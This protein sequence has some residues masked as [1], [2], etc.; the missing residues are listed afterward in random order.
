MA[1]ENKN[2]GKKIG[3]FVV[4]TVVTFLL[5]WWFLKPVA[6]GE[7][8][9]GEGEGE[10]GGGGGGG[11]Y[12]DVPTGF[13]HGGAK[14]LPATYRQP[15]QPTVTRSS[16]VTVSAQQPLTVKGYTPKVQIPQQ[17]ASTTSTGGGSGLQGALTGSGV[18]IGL[19]T[20]H[21]TTNQM[22]AGGTGAGGKNIGML[23][24]ASS[25]NLSSGGSIL[26]K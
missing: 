12:P 6:G 19:T 8:R 16:A 25:L 4:G 26:V 3:V 15:T 23:A 10:S 22:S 14:T 7:E 18:S 11:S 1:E 24:S 5:L 2:K 17:T 20:S 9:M 13:E 21:T